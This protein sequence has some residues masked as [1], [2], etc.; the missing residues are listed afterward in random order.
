MKG[1]NEYSIGNWLEEATT[2]ET[3]II[4]GWFHKK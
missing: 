2:L 3:I 1:T 4:S